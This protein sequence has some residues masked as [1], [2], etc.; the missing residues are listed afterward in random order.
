I[1][2]EKYDFDKLT[3][4]RRKL[5]DFYMPYMIHEKIDFDLTNF[6]SAINSYSFKWPE[7]D[8]TLLNNLF[9]FCDKIGY[10]KRKRKK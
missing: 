4:F 6:S 8:D 5:I 3:G 9:K 7:V 1:P 2:K 10:I